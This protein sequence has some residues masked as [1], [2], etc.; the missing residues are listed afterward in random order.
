MEANNQTIVWLES[1]HEL[2]LVAQ[3]SF[4][5]TFC[6]PMFRLVHIRA[7]T[8]QTWHSVDE[9]NSDDMNDLNFQG[10]YLCAAHR[11]LI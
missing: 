5:Q 6:R 2:S 8:D 4:A 1:S 9:Q 7:L 11:R 3:L 10:S